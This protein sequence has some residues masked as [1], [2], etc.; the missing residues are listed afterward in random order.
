MYLNNKI[1]QVYNR[2]GNDGY[3]TLI[4]GDKNTGMNG[5]NKM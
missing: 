5:I 4:Y 2:Y 1:F 3:L